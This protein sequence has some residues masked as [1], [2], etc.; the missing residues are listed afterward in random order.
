MGHLGPF[1]GQK[2]RSETFIGDV[3]DNLPRLDCGIDCGASSRNRLGDLLRSLWL[4]LKTSFFARQIL[5]IDDELMDENQK[6]Q[7][8]MK[9]QVKQLVEL[10]INT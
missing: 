9:I 1:E 10:R 7:N 5:G 6:H 2:V 3:E 4:G 8:Y